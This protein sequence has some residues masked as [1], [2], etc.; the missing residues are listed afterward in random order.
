M[1]VA[2]MNPC[3]CGRLYDSF[4]NCVCTPYQVQ[5]YWRKLS[6][7]LLDRID[8]QLEVPRLKPE[9]LSKIPGGETSR[10]IRSRVISSTRLQQRR[11]AGSKIFSNAHMTPKQIKEFCVLEKEAEILL[12]SAIVHFKLSA[13]AYDKVLKVARTIADLEGAEIIKAQHIAEA[14]QYRSLDNKGGVF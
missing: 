12:K 8:L 13:R 4:R 14:T 10:Q 7:P 11:F 2:S 5:N 9:E 3:P 1:L 6:G